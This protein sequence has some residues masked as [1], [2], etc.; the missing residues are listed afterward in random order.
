MVIEIVLSENIGFCSGVLFA[1][2]LSL[3]ALKEEKEI[4]MLGELVHNKDVNRELSEKGLRVVKSVKEVPEGK[5]LILPAH[6]ARKEDVELGKRKN[7]KLIPATCPF[8]ERSLKIGRKVLKEGNFL[9]ILGEKNHAEVRYLYS[10]LKNDRTFALGKEDEIPEVEGKVEVIIQSTMSED[11][12][13]LMKERIIEKNKFV[14]FHNTLCMESVKRQRE[15][16]KL[17]KRV[18]LL[19]VVGG[20]NS[21][22]TKRL[23]EIGKMYTNAHHIE[24][25]RDIRS[26]WFEGVK[27]V[28]ITSGTSTPMRIIERV[29]KRCLE[30][31]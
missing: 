21:S 27:V 5:T 19:L 14:T 31:Q 7:L 1:Y 29:K 10:Y 18:D 17:S 6:G 24:T 25:E 16:R 30:L 8:V 20:L 4:Y 23:Y 22:N 3:K 15:V 11:F 28:G 2:K 13:N 12:Y 9:F 26:E